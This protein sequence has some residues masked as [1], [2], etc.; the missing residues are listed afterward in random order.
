MSHD[1]GDD[2]RIGVPTLR[3]RPLQAPQ[4]RPEPIFPID[5]EPV[6][7]DGET[8]LGRPA[9]LPSHVAPLTDDDRRRLRE[10]DEQQALRDLVEA[11]ELMASDP[12]LRWFGW[13][14]HPL[15]A[16]FLLGSAGALGLFLYSQTL[17]ILASL[18]TQPE[19]MQYIGYAGLAICGGVVVVAMLRFLFI[20]VKLRR[21]RRLSIEGTEGCHLWTRRRRPE[22]GR[23][24]S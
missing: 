22:I 10:A 8:D 13:F 4:W 17:S 6:L 11:E 3:L 23:A 1:I 14:A 24:H 7:R 5:E 2:D 16:A 20:Y 15:A 21:N 19:W 12:A 18:A 9:Q